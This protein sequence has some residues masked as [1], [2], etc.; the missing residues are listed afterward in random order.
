MAPGWLDHPFRKVLND[1]ITKYNIDLDSYEN[2]RNVY[3]IVRDKLYEEI[4]W[5]TKIM[6][7]CTKKQ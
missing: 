7:N 3:M 6:S 1:G 2:T 4:Q 5:T